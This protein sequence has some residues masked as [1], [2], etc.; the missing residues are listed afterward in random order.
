MIK[1]KKTGQ[2]QFEYKYLTNDRYGLPIDLSEKK[3]WDN[4]KSTEDFDKGIY[5][6]RLSSI[7]EKA[8]VRQGSNQSSIY[9]DIYQSATNANYSSEYDDDT[10]SLAHPNHFFFETLDLLRAIIVAY[11]QH[12][13]GTSEILAK[14]TFSELGLCLS[15]KKYEDIHQDYIALTLLHNDHI[16][17]SMFSH[18]H[19][20]LKSVS[21][22][23]GT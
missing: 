1:D 5:R 9:R 10:A 12:K 19:G 13:D 4:L 22:R 23:F 21:G 14:N 3:F 7:I 17:N 15:Q 16:K 18:F 20:E 6:Q 2:L 11:N 8:S